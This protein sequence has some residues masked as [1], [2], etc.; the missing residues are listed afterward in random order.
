MHFLKPVQ[1]PTKIVFF[2]I[3]SCEHIDY[4]HTDVTNISW[5][6]IL[7]KFQQRK[8][9]PN[10]SDALWNKCGFYLLFLFIWIKYFITLWYFYGMK[11]LP[12]TWKNAQIKEVSKYQ[13]FL[14]HIS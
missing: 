3:S 12:K 2:A 6:T 9:E 13:A 4:N 5:Q 11:K 8:N 10:K 14:S 1:P 7:Y